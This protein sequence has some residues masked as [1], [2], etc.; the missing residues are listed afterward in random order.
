MP[1]LIIVSMRGPTED[2]IAASD[3]IE[4]GIGM[5][6]RLLA[7]VI[8]PT[9]DGIVLVNLWASEEMRRASNDDPAHK[10]IV[11]ASGIAELAEDTTARRY[12]TSRLRLGSALG[13]GPA[14]ELGE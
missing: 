11:Q 10:K 4:L 13:A 2:L 6:E 1:V 14:V 9:E 8:A 7:R 5:P 3:R 12:E